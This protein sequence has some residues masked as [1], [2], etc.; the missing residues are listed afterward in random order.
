MHASDARE[1]EAVNLPTHDA[2]S[3]LELWLVHTAGMDQNLG[4]AHD[5]SGTT[6]GFSKSTTRAA[7]SEEQA[8][9]STTLSSAVDVLTFVL[10]TWH[11]VLGEPITPLD[12]FFDLGGGSVEALRMCGRVTAT[13]GRTVPVSAIFDHRTAEQFAGYLASTLGRRSPATLRSTG[14]QNARQP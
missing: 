3:V 2:G 6:A 10:H 11:D 12:D 14:E 4:P 7:Q 8:E 13:L 9:P 1:P 5:N